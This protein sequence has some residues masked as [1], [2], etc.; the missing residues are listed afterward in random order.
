M[1][2]EKFRPL[3]EQF[4]VAMMQIVWRKNCACALLLLC[5]GLLTSCG[6]WRAKTGT[7]R[8]DFSKDF[9]VGNIPW[10]AAN[11]SDTLWIDGNFDL[12]IIFPSGREFKDVCQTVIVTRTGTEM[13]TIIIHFGYGSRLSE[14]KPRAEQL[15]LDWNF[16]AICQTK[17]AKWYAKAEKGQDM[18]VQEEINGGGNLSLRI[19]PNGHPAKGAERIGM[20]TLVLDR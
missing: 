10:P 20:I 9:S 11:K 14:I 12:H 6:G 18:G 17:L 16:P 13:R 1:I 3:L 2:P 15:L 8:W 5:L 19:S 7:Y 4:G